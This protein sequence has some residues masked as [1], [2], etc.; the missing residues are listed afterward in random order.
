MEL[1]TLKGI[2]IVGSIAN[3]AV[4]LDVK[5]KYDQLA[6]I[7]N[8]FGHPTSLNEEYKNPSELVKRAITQFKEDGYMQT[9]RNIE[10]TLKK[11]EVDLSLLD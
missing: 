4:E 6:Q 9:A 3:I 10:N 11:S 7:L 5:I 1:N 8:I 2:R